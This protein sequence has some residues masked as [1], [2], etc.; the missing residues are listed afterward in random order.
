M[1]FIIFI[2]AQN[3]TK[4]YP[5]IVNQKQLSHLFLLASINVINKYINK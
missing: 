3:K 5:K 4:K 1:L 2:K